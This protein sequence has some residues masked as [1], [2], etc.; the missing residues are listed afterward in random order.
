MTKTQAEVFCTWMGR[1]LP[2][3]VEWEFAA[4]GKTGEPPTNQRMVFPGVLGGNACWN[5][6]ATCLTGS[7]VKTY[8]GQIV[9]AD[10]PGFYDLLGNVWRF[11]LNNASTSSWRL[12]KLT[13]LVNGSGQVQP[14]TTEP[15]LATIQISGVDKRMVYVG[16]GQYLG[17][18]DIPGVV[19][20][21]A[22]ATQTQSMYALVDDLLLSTSSPT[23]HTAPIRS[24]MQ[25]R[26][27]TLSSGTC[28]TATTATTRSTVDTSS[29]AAAYN[30]NV[31]YTSQWGWYVD[32]P[33]TGERVNTTPVLALGTLYFTSNIPN[34][35]PCSP[36]GS[37]WL[38]I[39]DYKTGADAEALDGVDE[40]FAILALRKIDADDALDGLRHLIAR[41]AGMAYCGVALTEQFELDRTAMLAAIAACTSADCEGIVSMSRYSLT[42]LASR[43]QLRS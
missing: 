2:T 3:E 11:D 5:M 17:A 38:N 19:G 30:A 21:N 16:T 39:L 42:T 24:N 4:L 36:G 23:A 29:N 43:C 33:C 14:V 18:K 22:S 41:Q 12:Q 7:Y 15:E 37:S 34:S 28:A 13:A 32:L 31:N 9:A 35:D 40:C 8:L 20:A 25:P 10:Q 1:R 27:L 26:S 6:N